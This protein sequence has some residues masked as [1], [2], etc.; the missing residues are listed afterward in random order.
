MFICCSSFP[1]L[2]FPPNSIPQTYT[3]SSDAWERM[4]HLVCESCKHKLEHVQM[5]FGIW[6]YLAQHTSNT[7]RPF[8]ELNCW[9]LYMEV[10]TVY[11]RY[12]S[13]ICLWELRKITKMSVKIASLYLRLPNMRNTTTYNLISSL[14]LLPLLLLLLYY[15]WNSQLRRCLHDGHMTYE[16]PCNV[17]YT[18]TNISYTITEYKCIWFFCT[19]VSAFYAHHQVLSI[20]FILSIWFYVKCK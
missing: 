15:Y 8:W 19:H 11:S 2:I 17:E 14:L 7:L 4:T 13:S 10:F 16:V 18:F 3:T 9:I 12:H 6:V 1:S 5:C 20:W